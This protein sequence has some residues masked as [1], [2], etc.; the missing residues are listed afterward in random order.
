MPGEDKGMQSREKFTP[1]L[2]E[3]RKEMGLLMCLWT[4]VQ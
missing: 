1:Q 2:I 3:Q 4:C